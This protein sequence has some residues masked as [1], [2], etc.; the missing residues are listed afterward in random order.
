MHMQLH[1]KLMLTQFQ[2]YAVAV[3]TTIFFQIGL[4]VQN[5]QDTLKESRCKVL[6]LQVG[7]CA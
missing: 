6:T 7:L 5:T 2:I 3:Y 4:A 1:V